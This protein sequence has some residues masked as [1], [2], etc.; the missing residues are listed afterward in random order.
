M[1]IPDEQDMNE[2]AGHIDYEELMI[3]V[4]AGEAG[5]EDQRQLREWLNRSEANRQ[6]FA[7]FRTIF[8]RVDEA[9]ASRRF[10]A[11]KA[12]Q[13]L[14]ARI[15]EM[16]NADNIRKLPDSGMAQAFQ[17]GT[18]FLRVAAMI[19]LVIGMG[20]LA[21]EVQRNFSHP[22]QLATNS[23]T[24]HDTLQDGTAI[25]LNAHSTLQYPRR[26]AAN[27]RE[28]H[29]KGEA[30]FKVEHN[31]SRPFIIHANGLNVKVVGTQFDVKAFPGQQTV[32]VTVQEGTVWLM[33][34][35]NVDSSYLVL[36]AGQKGEYNRETGRLRLLPTMDV[37]DL[38]WKTK[39]LVFNKT[40]LAEVVNTLNKSYHVDVH[41]QN[42]KLGQCRLSTSF[43]DEPF[44]Q[45]LK[46]IALT[47]DLKISKSGN[48][49]E[50]QGEGC[51]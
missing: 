32:D 45:V 18:W 19:V 5:E 38:F 1:S 24:V 3:E 35:A 44:D 49:I 48:Q 28:V 50:L 12:W 9:A 42:D 20:I 43:K 10:D 21:Y 51:Q 46:V 36:K 13:K 41:L 6:E 37:N 8:G 17:S 47:F 14:D 25:A 11:N 34:E 23:E 22:Q 27:S 40:R 30:F 26:F 31:K 16:G 29:L 4:L 39:T 7:Q 15:N 2:N 33:P